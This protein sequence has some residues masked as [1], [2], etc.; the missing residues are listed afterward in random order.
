MSIDILWRIILL[1]ISMS[2]DNFLVGVNISL[3]GKNIPMF[4]ITLISFINA[5]VTFITIY[6]GI[7]ILQIVPLSISSKLSAFIFLWLG[8][9][10]L[11]VFMSDKNIS[12][13]YNKDI[14]WS[15]IYLLSLVL[16][17]NNIAWGIAASVAGFPILITTFI[18]FIITQLLMVISQLLGSRIGKS[19]KLNNNLSLV[20]A[21]IFFI[22]AI[23][24]LI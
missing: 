21:S 22:I 2:I 20:S 11:K 6:F 1:C 19:F 10:E 17:F 16:S 7:I 3:S 8:Y 15:E 9:K 12:T 24:S 18:S 5:F 4:G 23:N 14:S 13:N